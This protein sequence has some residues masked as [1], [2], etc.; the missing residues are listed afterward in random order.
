MKLVSII[1]ATYNCASDI[2]GYL[3]AF[4]GLDQSYFDWIIVDGG[5]TDGTSDILAAKSDLFSYFVSERDC[6]FYSA[7]NKALSQVKTPYYMIFGAD[8]RPAYNLF[9]AALPLLRT[10]P[11]LVLGGVRIM[12]SGNLKRPG[13]RAWHSLAIGRALSH[14]S[15]GSIIRAD[16]HEKFGA[17]DVVYP[18]VADSLF[19]RR[20]LASD[21][22]VLKTSYV[23]GEFM[24]GGMSARNET[25]AL[26]ETFLFQTLE[27]SNYAVQLSLLNLRLLKCGVIRWLH[28]LRGRRH[29]DD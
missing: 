21:E 25:R 16:L 22:P 19:L 1:T 4:Q 18:I 15:V 24:S 12:P 14:H 6:G 26:L 9:E 8:D 7:L 17:Y 23:F 10:S 5:S 3:E 13:S 28:S 2:S 20:V 27:G 29:V 11:A